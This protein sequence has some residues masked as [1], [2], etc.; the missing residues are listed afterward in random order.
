MQTY[1][2]YEN[3]NM[4]E[5]KDNLVAEYFNTFILMWLD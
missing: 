2:I 1:I 5:I 4:P 3:L